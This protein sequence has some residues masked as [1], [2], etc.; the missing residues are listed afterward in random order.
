MVEF[1]AGSAP[2][3]TQSLVAWGR[4]DGGQPPSR[5]P[6]PHG[7]RPSMPRQRPPEGGP[8]GR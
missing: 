7:G 2:L 4:R 8:N 6:V 3:Y 1:R 5:F